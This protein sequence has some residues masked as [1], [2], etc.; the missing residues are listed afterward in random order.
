MITLMQE[1]MILEMAKLIPD[2][3][4]ESLCGD[5]GEFIYF[6]PCLD[7]HGPRVKFYGGTIETST[8][9]NAP[10]L[11]F[12]NQGVTS[13]RLQPWMNKKKCP[14]AYDAEY[15]AKIENFVHKTLPVLLLVWYY[16]LDEARALKFFE[17]SIDLPKLL[18]YCT[19]IDESVLDKVK[20][21]S[22]LSELQDVCIKNNVYTF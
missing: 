13:L 15:V 9:R 22:T 8:T 14:N 19:G 10:S 20:S 18:S 11:A 21:C 4:D 12:T 1:D 5:F 16:K 6:S 17:G 7:T 2:Y 3:A